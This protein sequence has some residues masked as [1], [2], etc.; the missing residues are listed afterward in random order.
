M[1][2][3]ERLWFIRYHGKQ[4]VF[5]FRRF[6]LTRNIDDYDRALLFADALQEYFPFSRGDILLIE[7]VRL[8]EGMLAGRPNW[9]D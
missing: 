7:I 6:E 8:I 9:K 4:V 3:A 2:K 1:T 5:W